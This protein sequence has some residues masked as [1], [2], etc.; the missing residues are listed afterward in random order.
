M[1]KPWELDEAEHYE[2]AERIAELEVCLLD[3][4][5]LLPGDGDPYDGTANK[6]I[7]ATIEGVCSGAA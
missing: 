2:C 4:K 7:L 3:I 6:A 5:N 1:V